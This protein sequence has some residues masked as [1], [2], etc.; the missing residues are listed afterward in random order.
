MDD[1]AGAA[2]FDFQEA[3][4]AGGLLFCS[5]QIGLA[6]DGRVPADPEAQFAAALGALTGV[7]QRHGCGIADL[8]D[9]TSFHVGY[10]AHMDIFVAALAKALPGAKTAWTAIGVAALG[11]PDS[12]VEIK[13]IARMPGVAVRGAS[14][15][16]A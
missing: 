16:A 6:S 11:Y 10:P 3:R 9:L 5:G 2:G 4:E 1:V 14:D 8:V 13:A 15:V 12:L 7:L